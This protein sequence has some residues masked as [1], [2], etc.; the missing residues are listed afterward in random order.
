MKKLSIE[1]VVL[2]YCIGES[3]CFR[4]FDFYCGNVW[5]KYWYGFAM[6]V[7]ATWRFKNDT[8]LVAEM[9]DVEEEHDWVDDMMSFEEHEVIMTD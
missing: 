4:K 1:R 9:T 5:M 6:L 3:W 8:C 7:G 2:I